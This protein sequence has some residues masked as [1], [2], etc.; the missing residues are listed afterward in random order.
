MMRWHVRDH[1]APAERIEQARALIHLLAEGACEHPVV[2]AI[3][4][5][6]VKEQEEQHDALLFHDDLA[7]MNE[8]LL[9]ID[10]VRRA[11]PHGLK[12]LAEAEFA[13]MVVWNLNSPAVEFLTTLG[14]DVLLQQQYR[15][16]FVF[17]A[18]RQTLLCHAEAPA[19]KEPET[20]T[21][22]R[23]F[24]ASSTRPLPAEAPVTSR[25]PVRFAT[26]RGCEVTTPHPLSKV[27]SLLLGEMW[28]RWISVEAL[29]A[30]AR[31]RL[32]RAGEP[33]PEADDELRLLRFLLQGYG[34]EFVHLRSRPCPFVTTP[35]ERPRASAL[36]RLQGVNGAG[37]TNLQHEPVRLDDALV[38]RLLSLLDG[39]RDR[40]AIEK[41]MA[42]FIRE[43][44]EPGAGPLLA[45]L[46]EAIERNLNRV[47][48]LALLE[49]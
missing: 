5:H 11:G 44:D 9:F 29:L 2:S 41:E 8:P 36:A 13:D 26:E 20:S 27:A 7:D 17:R 40:A 34:G 46:P 25:D 47:A 19:L 14:N 16:F 6:A 48:K 10:F 28:P 31:A 22:R 23:L 49:A 18:L 24:A 30:R 15:D 12:F 35:S 33:S 39:T 4:K 1:E 38:R 37:V 45:A 32:S 43:E 21:L 42:R 3:L